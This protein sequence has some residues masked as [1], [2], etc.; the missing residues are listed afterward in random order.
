MKSSVSL[1][2]TFLICLSFVVGCTPYTV[3]RLPIVNPQM[4]DQKEA[5]AKLV[6]EYT[7]RIM[8]NDHYK[9]DFYNVF[10]NARKLCGPI[11][12][13]TYQLEGV[14][15]VNNGRNT[16]FLF[17]SD[18][19]PNSNSYGILAFNFGNG[20]TIFRECQS[21]GYCKVWIKNGT[22]HF[23][24]ILKADFKEHM[25]TNENGFYTNKW[26]PGT[27]V[28]T[29]NLFL[30]DKTKEQQADELISIF[31]SSFPFLRYE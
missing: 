19:W 3:T 14:K 31:L 8:D 30:Y 6:P 15:S 25:L 26:I 17:S 21:N 11:V 2:L 28:D 18:R 13:G 12:S 16:V 27:R 23:L 20:A 24:E 9:Y 4:I 10:P 29:N 1:F 22:V 7:R 5:K